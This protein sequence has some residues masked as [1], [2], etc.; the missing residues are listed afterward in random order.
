MGELVGRTIRELRNPNG[1]DRRARLPD[2]MEFRYR[3]RGLTNSS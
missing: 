2:D 1:P 3:R